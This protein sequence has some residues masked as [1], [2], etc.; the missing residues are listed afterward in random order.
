MNKV[1]YYRAYGKNIKSQLNIDEFSEIDYIKN[2]D[3]DINIIL[4]KVP[5]QIKEL[6]EEG[7]GGSY[8]LDEIWFY[9]KDVAIYY[10]KNADTIIVDAE[11]NHDYNSLRT[12][13]IWRAVACCLL[14]KNIV[15]IHGSAVVIDEKAVIITGESG[16][17]KSTI[18]AAL[19]DKNY[20]FL[21][22]ELCVVEVDDYN[23]PSLNPGYPE[24]RLHRD[25]MD[26]LG[27]DYTKYTRNKT[28]EEMYAIPAKNDFIDRSKVLG[29]IIEIDVSDEIDEVKIMEVVGVK[30]LM[31]VLNTIYMYEYGKLIGSNKEYY[32]RC[33]D[34][35]KYIKYF[36][37]TR[38]KN[39]FT[40][41]KQIQLI[42]DIKG[43][44]Y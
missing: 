38:P 18:T 24:Q 21:S 37:L 32:K 39:S 36:K 30:K 17:G 33:V 43:K 2:E 15:S 6:K 19:R 29:T 35:S 31:S 23:I 41:N 28:S 5:K 34:I 26:K 27:Y 3:V 20:S 44:M 1:F 10:I 25:A 12:F 40:V 11:V 22:D 16:A 4:G 42:E 14:Q 7:K 13:L 9:A 8:N